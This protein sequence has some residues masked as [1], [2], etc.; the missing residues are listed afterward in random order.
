M[1]SAP[2][3]GCVVPSA[4]SPAAHCCCRPCT[5][6]A[7][8]ARPRSPAW[9]T[10]WLRPTPQRC[11]LSYWLCCRRPPGQRRSLLR[12]QAPCCMRFRAP[13][14]ER[15]RPPRSPAS[16]MQSLRIGPRCCRRSLPA[17]PS[18]PAPP[19]CWAGWPRSSTTACS[20]AG[21]GAAVW[22]S[23]WCWACCRP[24]PWGPC[25]G[26]AVSGPSATIRPSSPGRP[27]VGSAPAGST[28]TGS[29]PA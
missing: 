9:P 20:M 12:C 23:C 4:I 3:I 7:P 15:C 28:P 17:W 10:S 22:C 11:W 29:K 26:C 18:P 5:A 27:G 19:W 21:A 24:W 8:A 2:T 6:R 25:G 1:P 16:P 14:R 13:Y